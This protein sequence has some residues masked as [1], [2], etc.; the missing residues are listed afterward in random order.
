MGQRR[1]T[2]SLAYRDLRAAIIWGT[3]GSSSRARR[4]RTARIQPLHPSGVHRLEQEGFVAALGQG[5]SDV[6]SLHRLTL[7]GGKL[8][9][10]VGHLGG[11]AARMAASLP[12]P[13][14]R[15]RCRVACLGRRRWQ[16]GTQATTSIGRTWA[17]SDPGVLT[18]HRAGKPQSR[19][20][21]S[22][23]QCLLDHDT[24]FRQGT[25]SDR[26][27]YCG[28]ATQMPPSAC[29]GDEL[30]QRSQAPPTDRHRTARRAGSWRWQTERGCGEKRGKRKDVSYATRK[31]STFDVRP[32]PT[33]VQCI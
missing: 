33:Y 16:R 9:S 5:K 2:T 8:F 10:I 6:S 28:G 12:R 32:N 25:R 13:A 20:L 24:R 3:A 23:R 15:T 31:R 21:Y 27:C 1:S 29:G 4:R 19:R 7:D 17:W 14:P 18:L 26:A 11:L 22:A 30:A